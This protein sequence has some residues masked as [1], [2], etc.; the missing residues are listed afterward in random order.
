VNIIEITLTHL[1]TI[2]ENRSEQTNASKKYK[3]QSGKSK[4]GRLGPQPKERV[5]DRRTSVFRI[6]KHLHTFANTVEPLPSTDIACQPM[7][8]T[9]VVYKLYNRVFE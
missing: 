5:N 4:Q 8:T 7:S 2:P 9:S 3:R 6:V 1:T